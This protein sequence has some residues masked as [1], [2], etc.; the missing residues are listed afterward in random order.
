MGASGPAEQPIEPSKEE[1]DEHMLTHLPFRSWCPH[2]VRGRAVNAP[3]RK[4]A[5][6]QG[7]VAV[8]SMDY[9]YMF[10]SSMDRK[11]RKLDINSKDPEGMSILVMY[12]RWG[13]KVIAHVIR[14]KACM[15][16][17][18]IGLSWKY[19]TWD[20]KRSYSRVT[21]RGPLKH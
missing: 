13:K 16:M 9:M 14:E 12:D 3:H 17:P 7:K 8:V 4:L 2:C 5:T 6:R 21:R 18:P 10:E 1:V 19:G 20:T 15:T 11:R